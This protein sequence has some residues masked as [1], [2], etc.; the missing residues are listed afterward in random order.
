[1]LGRLTFKNEFVLLWIYHVSQDSLLLHNQKTGILKAAVFKV[2]L[3]NC[4]DDFARTCA[5]LFSK[6]S[7]WT[8]L[9][10]NEKKQS[11]LSLNSSY[12]SLSWRLKKYELTSE[13]CGGVVEK[14]T[15]VS[16]TK[17]YLRERI[18]IVQVVEE[19]L[20]KHFA[21]RL[22]LC[23]FVLRN[24]FMQPLKTRHFIDR[25]F[26]RSGNC[27]SAAV[28]LEIN[29]RLSASVKPA[30]LCCSLDEANKKTWN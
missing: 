7:S 3:H 23:S 18:D 22:L 28:C 21:F 24:E 29:S 26:P 30:I 16:S 2:K 8:S 1:M 15:K 14:V 19:F 11:L 17:K 25:V 6:L 9:K 13:R 12:F 10:V 4:N 5:N 27:R 20:S